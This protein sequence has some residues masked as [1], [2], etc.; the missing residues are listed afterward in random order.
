MPVMFVSPE[1]QNIVQKANN[2]RD[3][4]K[5]KDSNSTISSWKQRDHA[6]NEG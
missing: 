5:V 6:F 1:Y 2:K 4:Y 3:I